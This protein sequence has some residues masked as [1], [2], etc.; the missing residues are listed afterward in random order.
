MLHDSDCASRSQNVFSVAAHNEST[1]TKRSQ[2][3]V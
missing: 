2:A 1:Y 3:V